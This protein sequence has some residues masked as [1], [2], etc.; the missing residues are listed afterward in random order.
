MYLPEAAFAREREL[1][2]IAIPLAVTV[3]ILVSVAVALL[4]AAA[5]RRIGWALALIPTRA[6]AVCG[7][8]SGRSQYFVG[9]GEGCWDGPVGTAVG[10]WGSE[11]SGGGTGTSVDGSLCAVEAAAALSLGLV[12]PHCGQQ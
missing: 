11:G 9:V 8:L 12:L 10:N 3:T 7:V 6:L 2:V 1:Y 4:V 5:L